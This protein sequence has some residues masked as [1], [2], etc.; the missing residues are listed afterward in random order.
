MRR[1]LLAARCSL[2]AL[3]GMLADDTRCQFGELPITGQ[4]LP[5]YNHPD[6]PGAFPQ[7]IPAGEIWPASFS[8]VNLAVIP[9][10][11]NA[12]TSNVV[13]AWDSESRMP[14][15]GVPWYQRYTVGNPEVPSSFK[16]RFVQIPLGPGGLFYGDLFCSG[17]CWLPN[18]RLFIAGGNAQYPFSPLLPVQGLNPAGLPLPGYLGSRYVGIWDPAF[19]DVGPNYG[20]THL[21]LDNTP[22]LPMRIPRWY[23]TVT[24]VSPRY[25]MVSGGQE[26]TALPQ[27]SDRARD[28]YELFDLNTMNWVTD[29][30]SPPQPK[31]FDGPRGRT[32]AGWVFQIEIGAYPPLHLLSNNRTFSTGILGY[33]TSIDTDPLLLAGGVWGTPQSG[34]WAPFLTSG[35][36]R[37]GAPSVLVP[38]VGN[39][40]G[41]EDQV[42]FIGGGRAASSGPPAT[43]SSVSGNSIRIDA[44][45]TTPP[46]GQPQSVWQPPQNLAG[47]PRMLANAVLAPSGDIVLIGGSAAY[48]F[49]N[50]SNAQP[51]TTTEVWDRASGWRRDA[52]Q[53]GTRMYHSTAALL[54]SGNMV[55]GGGDIR[56]VI[57]TNPLRRA[58]WEVYVPRNLTVGHPRPTFAGAWSGPGALTMNFG[59]P[60][61]IPFAGL[62]GGGATV[63]RVV[64]MRPCSTT[65]NTDMDQRYVEIPIVGASAGVVQVQ[66]P[67]QT[68]ASWVGTAPRS[69]VALPGYYMLF[70]VSSSGAYSEAKWVRLL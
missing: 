6:L 57:G 22:T 13:I 54:P 42:M 31:V 25:V 65:H 49:E 9:N 66:L 69:I 64:L 70:L 53:V 28:T 51:Q 14:S 33:T 58:D 60:Y 16:N 32:P 35:P 36:I 43:P 40:I 21:A 2:L 23:P 55:S 20:W 17:H 39:L 67:N 30:A 48:Y 18:G 29:G 47:G 1:S 37:V 15:P 12:V 24:L 11:N 52:S 5:P 3:A 61:S 41:L 19:A 26:D 46:A 56:T 59:V 62:S 44:A 27:A 68:P 38:N 50:S 63:A 34:A 7:G 45:M 10:P 4:W 8:A